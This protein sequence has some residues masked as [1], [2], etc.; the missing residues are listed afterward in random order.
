[1][2]CFHPLKAWYSVDG[3]TRGTVVFNRLPGRVYLATDL[4]CGKC[5][6]CR[7]EHARQW[8]IRCMHEAELHEDNCM[9]TLTY[10]DEHLP[11]DGSLRPEDPQLWMKRLRKRFRD[12][13]IS[14][15]LAG[16]YGDKH[17]RPHYHALLFGLDFQTGIV[18]NV[19]DKRPHVNDL[20]D[21]WGLGQVHVDPL[22]YETAA[23]VARYCLKKQE[24]E[25]DYCDVSTGVILQREYTRMSRRPAI[26]K[27]WFLANHVDTYKDDTVVMGTTISRPPRYYDKLLAAQD[28]EN[29]LKK[30]KRKRLEASF[31]RRANS[32]DERLKKREIVAKARNKLLKRRIENA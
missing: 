3:E 11:N 28:P 16:E 14:F 9:V 4:P 32:T 10:S 17:K 19:N 26:G 25:I 13:K 6:G 12:R 29:I 22:T 24:K 2:P 5:D 7:M 21:S 30:I 1:M 15:F 23:Y 18:Y 27:N 8:A 31:S 20:E